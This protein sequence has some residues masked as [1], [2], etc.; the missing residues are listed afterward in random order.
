V[1]LRDNITTLASG[2][3]VPAG[4]LRVKKIKQRVLEEGVICFFPFRNC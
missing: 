1:N 4:E 3:A 2:N